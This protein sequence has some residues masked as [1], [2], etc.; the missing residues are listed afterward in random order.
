MQ[1]STC[2]SCTLLLFYIYWKA[3]KGK[4]NLIH[5]IKSRSNL[6]MKLIKE[7]FGIKSDCMCRVKIPR[8][9]TAAIFMI[10]FCNICLTFFNLMPN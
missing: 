6:E 5:N 1:E 8:Q 4:S 7:L 9:A 10:S 3:N 2:D